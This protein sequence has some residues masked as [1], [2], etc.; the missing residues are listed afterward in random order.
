MKSA[1]GDNFAVFEHKP[2]NTEIAANQRAIT[3]VYT[4]TD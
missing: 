3:H 2:Q 1:A 4:G